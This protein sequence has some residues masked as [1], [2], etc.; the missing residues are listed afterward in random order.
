MC[1]CPIRQFSGGYHADNYF[2]CLLTFIFII[3]S[4]ILI[5]ENINIDLFKNIIMIIA[6]VSWVGIC[7]LC[8]IEHRS[9][10]I[11]DR[12]K[13]VYKK[14]AIFISTVVLLITILS[15]SLSIFVDYFTYSAF[16]MFWIFV[17]LVL[18]KLKAKV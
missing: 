9:N 3:L 10:P 13:L 15:L 5:I 2:R 11:S 1:Y 7:V 16:A 4:T 17:M 18:G 14:T 8:P 12:E 6:S